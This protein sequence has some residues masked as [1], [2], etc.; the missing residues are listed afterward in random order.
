[1]ASRGAPSKLPGAWRPRR[2]QGPEAPPPGRGAW[3]A[4]GQPLEGCRRTG[5]ARI[6]RGSFRIR[7]QKGTKPLP[8]HGLEPRRDAPRVACLGAACLRGKPRPWAALGALEEG[9][10][11]PAPAHPK[12]AASGRRTFGTFGSPQ[13]NL[14]GRASLCQGPGPSKGLGT[15]GAA[16]TARLW[17]RAS[18]CQS[19]GR[20]PTRLRP[21]RRGLR[22]PHRRPL[23]PSRLSKGSGT[24]GAAP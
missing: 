5:L 11:R 8:R 20:R 2:P 4:L 12:G 13:P 15:Y 1:L 9:P 21:Q 14:W 24:E 10:R 6:R 16:P 18:L 17:G 23:R 7:R 19:P 3:E 22:P